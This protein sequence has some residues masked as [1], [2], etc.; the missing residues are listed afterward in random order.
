[1]LWF[2]RVLLK[3]NML[4]FNRYPCPEWRRVGA[5]QAF[6]TKALRRFLSTSCLSAFVANNHFRITI[7]FTGVSMMQ[8]R[9]QFIHAL[10]R[11]RPIRAGQDGVDIA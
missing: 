3:S 2:A 7:S 4:D 6:A 5:I 8:P 10:E 11:T 1:M 9:E